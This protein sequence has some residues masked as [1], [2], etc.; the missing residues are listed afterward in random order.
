MLRYRAL[1]SEDFTLVG[2][3][4]VAQG[5]AK[6]VLQLLLA[7]LGVL[8]LLLGETFGR[9][10]GLRLLWRG[11]SC[12][13]PGFHAR[14]LLRYWTYPV[15]QLPSSVL[16]SLSLVAPVPVF[17]MLY[18]PAVGGALAL[19]QRVVG[20]PV[21]LIGGAVADVF[22]GR[23]ST[24]V[25]EN[26]DRATN[27]F[28]EVSI[29]LGILGLCLGSGVWFLA[30]KI[31][32][33]LFGP[34]WKLA[35]NMMGVMGPWMAAQLTVSPVSR[36]VFLTPHAWLKLLYDVFSLLVITSPIWLWKH[37]KPEEA[38]LNV[39]LLMVGAYGLYFVVLLVL[40]FRIKQQGVQ[41]S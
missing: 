19:A 31:T 8:G 13:K 39:S 28:I 17:V 3:F 1:R 27:F 14:T 29:K 11:A 4:T 24:L 26:P 22:Y 25:R 30:P 10:V 16:N 32:P 6:V 38:L 40:A 37:N 33:W 23:V 36:F 18:G 15:F 35:G 21:A 5:W 2:R 41:W 9:L 34:E 20:L 7:P 12:C